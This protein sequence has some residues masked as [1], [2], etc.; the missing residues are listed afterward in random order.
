MS[1]P[2]QLLV[3]IDVPDLA[4]AADFYGKALG[5]Q[6]GRRLGPNGLELLGASSPIYLLAKE[7][8]SKPAESMQQTRSYQR[9]W[10]PVHIDLVVDDIELAAQRALAAGATPEGPISTSAWGRLAMFADPFGHGFCL[11]QFLGK[12]Y[13]EIADPCC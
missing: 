5:L 7:A 11:L 9:H 10:T 2:M 1:L 3:N 8:G 13:D 12:G 6:V 4:Q